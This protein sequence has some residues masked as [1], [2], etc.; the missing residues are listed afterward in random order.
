MIKTLLIIIPKTSA[1]LKSSDAETKWMNFLIKNA[2]YLE[3]YTDIW[4]KV[5]KIIKKEFDCQPVHI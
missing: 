1:Y 2:E 4:I 5:N 3:K